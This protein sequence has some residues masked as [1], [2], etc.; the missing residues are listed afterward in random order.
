[1]ARK[2]RRS[3]RVTGGRPPTLAEYRRN[4]LADD[5]DRSPEYEAWLRGPRAQEEARP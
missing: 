3:S 4:E 5:D 2:S 1:M